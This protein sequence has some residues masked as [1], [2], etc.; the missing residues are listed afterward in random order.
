MEPFIKA[1][2]WVLFG[3]CGF[4]F[5]AWIVTVILHYLNK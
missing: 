4:V 2:G 1:I 5:A 3:A